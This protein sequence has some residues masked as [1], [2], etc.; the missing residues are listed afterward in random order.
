MQV[1]SGLGKFLPGDGDLAFV[2]VIEYDPA[3]LAT[4]PYATP[5]HSAV[6]LLG[7]RTKIEATVTFE[8]A[9]PDL[10]RQ[11]LECE[12]KVGAPFVGKLAEKVLKKSMEETYSQLPDIV[13]RWEEMR[14]D[15][16]ARPGGGFR[17]L[18]ASLY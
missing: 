12:C 15:M 8:D 18:E 13:A 3:L 7:N 17:L 6:P 5:I 10:T 2:D 1:P 11:V 4:T 9:G 14:K 16:M